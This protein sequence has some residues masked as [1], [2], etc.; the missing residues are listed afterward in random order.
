MPSFNKV[1]LAGNLCADPRLVYTPKGTPFARMSIAVNRS[2]KAEDGSKRDEVTFVNCD[3]WGATAE[4]MAKYLIK[5]SGVII[6][7]RL[8][9]EK[10]E[11]DGQTHKELKVVIESVSFTDKK[12]SPA[13]TSD[14]TE[15]SE[16]DDVPF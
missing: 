12:R 15:E 1:I 3:A 9:C 10:W 16:D 2:W 6:E 14:K 5:G 11:K 7:G 8:R 4:A 13:P